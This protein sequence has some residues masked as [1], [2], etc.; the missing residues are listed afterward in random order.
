MCDKRFIYIY[1]CICGKL[2][3]FLAKYFFK[4]GNNKHKIQDDY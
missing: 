4:Q 3:F 2:L 1:I